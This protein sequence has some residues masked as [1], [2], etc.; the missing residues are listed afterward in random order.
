MRVLRIIACIYIT[1][2]LAINILMVFG[3]FFPFHKDTNKFSF[4][5]YPEPK[6]EYNPPL[7]DYI[8]FNLRNTIPLAIVSVLLVFFYKTRYWGLTGIIA[9]KLGIIGVSTHSINE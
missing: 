3:I 7:H 1:F 9:A 2:S 5:Y 4:I 6:M 8:M